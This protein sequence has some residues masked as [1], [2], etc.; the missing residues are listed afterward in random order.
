MQHRED[1]VANGLWSPKRADPVVGWWDPS[2]RSSDILRIAVLRG[3]GLG[4]LM[5]ALPAV[6]R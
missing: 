5:F 3:G 4:D 1:W 2:W 6:R